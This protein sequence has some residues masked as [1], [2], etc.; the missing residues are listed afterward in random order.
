VLEV[1]PI[2][3]ELEELSA[4]GDGALERFA[5]AELLH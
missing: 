4:C 3:Y 5:R 1:R 2:G